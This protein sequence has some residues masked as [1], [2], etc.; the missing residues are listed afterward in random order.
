MAIDLAALILTLRQDL[1]VTK[2]FGAP[3]RRRQ[4][5]AWLLT[6]GLKEYRAL[7]EYGPFQAGLDASLQALWGLPELPDGDG[8][9]PWGLQSCILLARPDVQEAFDLPRDSDAFEAWFWAHAVGE[10]GLWPFLTKAQKRRALGTEGPWQTALHQHAVNDLMAEPVPA[11]QQRPWGV[12]LI[13]YAHGQLGIG[14]DVRMAARALL[15][16]GVP[17]CMVDF[18][19]GKDIPQNDHSMAA[20]VVD[21]VG[22][23]AVNVFCLTAGEHGRFFAERGM[24][25]LE[26][27]YNIGYWPWELG[28]W[29]APWAQLVQLVDE[30]WVSTRHTRD[31]VAP[32]CQAVPTPVPVHVMPMAV[33]LGSV[34]G[35]SCAQVRK[36]WGLPPQARLMVFTFDLNSSIHRKNPQAAVDAF[37]R[38][39]PAQE[40][41]RDQVGLVIK[42]HPPKRRHP[43]WERLKQ[44]A[45]QDERLHIIEQTL[46]RPELLALY[47]ACDV[48]VS[49]HRA[50]GFGRGI[51]EALQ[52][53][54]HVITTG[55]SGNVDFCSLPEFEGMVDLVRHRLVTVKPGQY[56][57]GD[58]Q[59]WAN[60]DLAHAASCMQ[61]FVQQCPPGRGRGRPHKT[62]DTGWDVFS[63]KE[64]G[65]RY[66][67]HLAHIHER[68]RGV[69][70]ALA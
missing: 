39:F 62:P 42:V 28:E 18:A 15:A 12:N 69:A 60:A 8:C 23:Y 5:M 22:P 57:F 33:E 21:G 31:A 17:M 36:R 64:V 24:A 27:R 37:L 63:A 9:A 43:A 2:D 49:L 68:L 38:A 65:H 1:A 35:G 47:R 19:P 56:P 20:H 40:W 7:A 10:H 51:A 53:G 55:Y 14:E 29:P 61:A 48:F 52:L 70:S 6:A 30:V 67:A 46:P 41:S 26:G 4:Y 66:A 25:Q 45:T 16:D 58:G 44:L 59:V 34:A 3:L 13:G 32:A 50:E 54:L 11:V